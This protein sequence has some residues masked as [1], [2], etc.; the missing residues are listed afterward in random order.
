MAF[1]G[2]GTA[3]NWMR[4]FSPIVTVPSPAADFYVTLDFDLAY[5]T[6]IDVSKLYTAFDGLT[7]RITDQTGG[8]AIRSVLAEAFAEQ[9]MTGS[10]NGFPKHLPRSN[11]ANY[12]ADQS[13]WAGWSNGMTHV[14]MKFPGA[15]MAGRAVQL[16]FEYTQDASGT[17]TSSGFPGTCGVA[18]D[19]VK[20]Q[21]VTLGTQFVATATNTSL[22]SDHNP[23][24]NGQTLTLTATVVPSPSLLTESVEFFDGAT[25]LGTAPVVNGSASLQTSTLSVGNHQLTATYSGDACDVSSTSSAYSQDILTPVGVADATPVAFGIRQVT[26]NPTSKASTVTFGLS[27]AERVAVGIY[28]LNGRQVKSVASSAF[29]AGMHT[30]AWDLRNASGERV[31]PGVY[32]V[33]VVAAEGA[34]TARFA[35]LQ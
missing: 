14:S 13:V 2:E 12:F 5:S 4:L 11:N 27:R 15:G 23:W 8:T 32:F 9:L 26:P 7:V 19:N 29:N 28:D 16:R 1:H 10:S 22:T 18:I 3:L 30:L 33:R 34:R 20:L 35:V 24:P 17:C 21:C 6:E 25:S 31:G